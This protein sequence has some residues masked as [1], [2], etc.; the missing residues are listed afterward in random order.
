MCGQEKKLTDI[1][2]QKNKAKFTQEQA[3]SKSLEYNNVNTTVN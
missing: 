1:A 3:I 2:Y